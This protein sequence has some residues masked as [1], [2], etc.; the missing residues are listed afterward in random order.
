MDKCAPGKHFTNGSCFSLD[1][2]I[3]IAL[4]YNSIYTEDKIDIVHDKKYLLRELTNKMKKRYNC[5]DQVCWLNSKVLKTL[6]N[7]DITHYTFRPKGPKHQYEWLSTNDINNVMSQ[8]KVTHPDFAF[9]G[10]LPYDFEE[11]EYTG[12]NNINF[13]E[14]ERTTP[15]IGMII[16]LDEHYKSGSHWVALYANLQNYKI[17]YF[18][19][20]GKKPGKRVFKFIIKILTYMYKKKYHTAFDIDVFLNKFHNSNEFDV[21][22]N[23]K[24]HQFKNT[25]CGVY[26]MNFLIRIL[27]N[28]NFDQIVNNITND[29]AMNDCRNIYFRNN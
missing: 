10:A 25:E 23:R 20:F 19:S 26:S 1:D 14:L 3:N 2:L 28:E 12:I 11:L 7:K 15:K 16:N 22:F 8:Y 5:L 9:I 6:G 4:H 17:Y 24:Q 18:D 21:R 27:N 13:E 29:D